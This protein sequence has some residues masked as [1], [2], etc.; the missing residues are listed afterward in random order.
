MSDAP[1]TPPPVEDTTATHPRRRVIVTGTLVARTAIHPGGH[2]AAGATDRA[3]ARDGSHRPHIPGTALAGALRGWLSRRDGADDGHLKDL[4]GHVAKEEGHASHL[5]VEDAPALNLKVDRPLPIRDS[6]RIDRLTGTAADRLKFDR[7]VLPAGTRF[8]LRMELDGGSD[9]ELSTVG[10][11]VSALERGAIRLGGGTARGLGRVGLEQVQWHQVD[12]ATRAGMLAHLSGEVA[13]L[14]TPPAGSGHGDADRLA[15]RVDW[16]PEGPVMVK[17]P[18]EVGSLKIAP[19]MEPVVAV[20]DDGSEGVH[21]APVIPGASI[22]GALRSHAE[23]IMRTIRGEATPDPHSGEPGR[24]DKSLQTE[25]LRVHLPELLFGSSPDDQGAQEGQTALPRSWRAAV[26]ITDCIA[27]EPHITADRWDAL[28]DHFAQ[29]DDAQGAQAALSQAGLETWRVSHHVAIDRW[30][31]GAADKMLFTVLEP[32]G[33]RWPALQIELDPVQLLNNARLYRLRELADNAKLSEEPGKSDCQEKLSWLAKAADRTGVEEP[34]SRD[35]RAALAL[36]VLV[37]EDLRR[38]EITLGFG[39]NRGM[40]AILVRAITGEGRL[41]EGLGASQVDADT[42]LAQ[43][44]EAIR[45]PLATA[46]GD[47]L[48]PHGE[49]NR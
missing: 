3:V 17:G 32:H 33:V 36:L 44:V 19:L 26:D 35:A 40:G 14:D 29:S 15:L 13:E 6:V 42:P 34:A 31:G 10:E 7:E 46:W 37:L 25:Q 38:G 21:L 39:A 18:V 22:K 11:V 30:L 24:A 1:V 45:E 41:P 9:D 5:L 47:H 12:L 16:E 28:L 49:E 8:D 20:R 43:I 27:S 23:L 4:F 48:Q 2:G